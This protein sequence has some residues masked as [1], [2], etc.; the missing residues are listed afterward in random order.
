MDP[1][2]RANLEN[3]QVGWEYRGNWPRDE[4]RGEPRPNEIIKVRG[5]T[6]TATKMPV[7]LDHYM[8]SG[9]GSV[10]LLGH[11]LHHLLST[12]DQNGTKAHTR[13]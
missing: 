9:Y 4:S 6:L 2:H 7:T 8:T 12:S 3:K 11:V 1:C 5:L 13:S 10:R